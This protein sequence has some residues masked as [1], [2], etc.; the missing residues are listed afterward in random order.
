M[1]AMTFSE[2]CEHVR[3]HIAE[4]LPEIEM[5][6]EPM[7]KKVEKNNGV[8][9]TGLLVSSTDDM[10]VAPNIY[11]E[12]YY[13]RYSDGSTMDS[14]IEEIADEYRNIRSNA[15]SIGKLTSIDDWKQDLSRVFVKLVSLER[16]RNQLADK[17]YMQFQDLAVTFRVLVQMDRNGV[18]STP[19]TND[20]LKDYGKTVEELYEI[21]LK[22]YIEKFPTRLQTF[23][24]LFSGRFDLPPLFMDEPEMYILTNDICVNGATTVLDKESLAQAREMIGEDFFIMPSS[25][26]ECILVP[27]REAMD[28]NGLAQLVYEVN[29]EVLSETDFLSDTVYHYDGE[30][31]EITMLNPPEWMKEKEVEQEQGITTEKEPSL[32]KEAEKDLAKG[33]ESDAPELGKEVVKEPEQAVETPRG[34]GG[35]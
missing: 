16:N 32:A 26:H 19:V 10:S 24:E 14:V 11:L 22:N 35:R 33:M 23:G 25:I 2:F 15:L 21:G 31:R 12:Y 7:L 4:H 9:F 28:K 27:E 20:M 30:T 17:P 6:R 13:Q 1:G 34:R 3:E 29:R 18:S 8:S 5:G